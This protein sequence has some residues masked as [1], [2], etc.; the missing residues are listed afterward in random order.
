[1]VANLPEEMV[2]RISSNIPLGHMGTPE[3][4]AN[5][6]LFLASELASYVTGAIISVDGATQV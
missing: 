3:D 6:F 4:V 2:Q 5:V 1:M